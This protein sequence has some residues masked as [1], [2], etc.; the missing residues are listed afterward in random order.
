MN[1]EVLGRLDDLVVVVPLNDGLGD[2]GET[3]AELDWFAFIY[4]LF[5]NRFEQLRSGVGDGWARGL[6][7]FWFTYA[8]QCDN[9]S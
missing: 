8:T 2:A 5:A 1:L 7:L 3:A 4:L 9:K 6:R